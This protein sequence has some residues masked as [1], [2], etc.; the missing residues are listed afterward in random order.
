MNIDKD[1]IDQYKRD[2]KIELLKIAKTYNLDYLTEEKATDMAESMHDYAVIDCI[3]H[4]TTA[5][6]YADILTY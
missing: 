2:V 3:E 6:E 5:A 1:T 4:G